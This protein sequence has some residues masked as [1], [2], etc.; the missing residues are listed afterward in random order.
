M[1]FFLLSQ[2][3]DATGIGWGEAIDPAKHPATS[4]TNT[5]NKELSG[6]TGQKYQVSES[7]QQTEQSI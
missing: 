6:P 5:H 3:G 4:R 2:L 1:V 7:L